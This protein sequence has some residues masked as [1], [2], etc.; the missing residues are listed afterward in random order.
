MIGSDWPVALLSAEYFET[1]DIVKQ[2]ILHRKFS[3]DVTAAILGDNAVRIYKL[4]R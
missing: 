1:M 3:D 4:R 2:W